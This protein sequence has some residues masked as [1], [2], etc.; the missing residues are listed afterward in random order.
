MKDLRDLK[1]VT[2]HDV[3][4]RGKR[5]PLVQGERETVGRV[6]CALKRPLK[7]STVALVDG[8]GGRARAG[9]RCEHH[10]SP[11]NHPSQT[12]TLNT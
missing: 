12:V 6:S 3:Q 5:D 10:R 7:E 9:A 2:I 11:P 1:D 8:V 4:P